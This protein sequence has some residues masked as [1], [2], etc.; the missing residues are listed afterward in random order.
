MATKRKLPD[1]P[2]SE[3][4]DFLHELADYEKN[5]SRLIH[6]Y[7]A[8]RKAASSIAKVDHKIE[9]IKDIK[10]LEGIG[11]KIEAK[12]EQYLSTGKIQKLETN[13]GD[14]TGA[15]I[16][17]LTRIMGIGPAHANKLVHQEKIKSIDELRSHPKRD[18]L[19]SKTQQL[20]LKY[21]EEFEQKIPRDEMKQMETILLREI[22]AIDDQ[23]KAEIV[24]SYRRG[25]AASSDI[26]VLVTHPTTTKLSSLIHKIVDVLTKK[27][28][29]I[30]DTISIGDSKFMGVCQMDKNKLHRRIDIRVF[31]SEQYYCALL[32][33][34]GN[35][36]LNRHMRIVAHEQGYKLNEYSVQKVGSTGV[37]SKPLPVTSE[38]DIFDYLQMDYK[39]PNERNM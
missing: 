15:S 29:F 16:N 28:H 4:V 23:L 32:Y 34:T 25:A 12:I 7:N 22:T 33:F 27:V 5:V 36:Q 1:N 39:E 30:T 20:G 13:R 6:K 19:L 26:D 37:L 10:G 3:L 8:Y 18:Q 38:K 9:T 14:A 24:G 11:K 35:D 31:P 17:E 21:L 2:N